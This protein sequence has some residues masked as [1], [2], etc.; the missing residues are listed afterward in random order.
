MALLGFFHI[1]FAY[2]ASMSQNS[3]LTELSSK[4]PKSL[5]SIRKHF[6]ISNGDITEYVVCQKCCTL[7]SLDDCIVTRQ[8]RAESKLCSYVEFP[9]HPH[10]SKRNKCGMVLMKQIRVGKKSNVPRKNFMY[11]SVIKTLKRLVRKPDFLAMCE[12]WRNRPARLPPEILGDVYEG[13]VWKSLNV[14]NNRPYLALPNNLCLC[15]NIDWFNPY[16]ESP[17]SVGAIYLVI[18]NLPRTERYKLENM[19]LV[20][21]IPGPKE[22]KDCNDF[23]FPLVEDLKILFHGVNMNTSS[24]K[25]FVRALLICISCDLPA[26]RKICGFQNFNAKHGCSKCLKEFPTISFGSKPN[27]GGYECQNWLLRDNSMHKS[28][29]L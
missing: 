18:L 3:D 24:T 10:M 1:L 29:A 7:Y 19:I 5:Y 16:D 25:Q 6:Q 17:Y 22:P 13:R 21:I 27:Y 9:N 14:V 11:Y 23:L 20:G 2:L 26:T 12:H 15:L 4:F 8:G 28:K